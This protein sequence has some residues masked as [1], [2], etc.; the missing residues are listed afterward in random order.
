MGKNK[1]KTRN[2]QGLQ[3]FTLCIS[4][5]MVLILLGMVVLTVFTARNLSS[6]VKENLTVT[7]LLGEDI[8]DPEAQQLCDKLVTKPYINKLE[9]ISKEQVLQE[10][11]EVLGTDPSE[12][13]GTNPFG[14]QIEFQLN[15]EYATNDSLKWISDELTK[16]PKVTE[17]RYPEDLVESVN[18]TLARMSLVLLVL[19][20]LLLI[21]SFVLINN[22]VKLGIYA[23]RFNIHTMKL[24][25]ASWGFI[26]RPFIKQAIVLGIVAAI[27]ALVVLAA[28]LY[29]LFRFDPEVKEVLTW[30]VM[31][32]TG[33]AVLLAGVIITTICS[34][35]SVNKFLKMKAG[36]L[37]KI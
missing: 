28:G 21:V 15:A 25:G 10:Q 24:V 7:M 6:Y 5:A 34:W 31:A 16:I 33:I 19:A 29:F 22:T 9:Y 8:T 11:K 13:A 26:R 23:R 18:K 3:V 17:I 27:I 4:T 2:R 12:F 1:N 14:S 37:Y 30:Q 20:G 35:L 32:I 36:E